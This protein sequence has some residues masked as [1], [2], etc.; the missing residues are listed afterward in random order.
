MN[1]LSKIKEF[2]SEKFSTG[3][4]FKF[5]YNT[6]ID[7]YTRQKWEEA[8]DYFKLAIE[9]DKIKPQ[10]YYNL[11][12]CYQRIKDYDKAVV[13]YQKFLEHNPT[14]Y[15]GLYNIAL[16]Y[17][18][19]GDFSKSVEFYEKCVEIKKD[20]DGVKSLALA[21][22][23]NNETQ[24]AI[25]FANNIFETQENGLILYY[26]IAQVFENKNAFGKDFTYIDT[27]IEM[28]LK[29][30]EKDSNF[31]D[32]YL[33]ISICYAKKAE[34]TKSVEFCEKA[35]KTNPNS[36]EA[37]NQMGL[38]YYCSNEI[39]EAVK[40]YE[41][42]LKLK[43]DGDYKIYSNLAYAYEKAEKYN[44][45][46]RIFTKLLQKFPDFPAKDEIKN[47]MRILKSS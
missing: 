39:N 5:F 8:I 23:S 42:A 38:V 29:I 9:Q 40:Y 43:P 6:G 12:L 35:L 20:K 18:M 15:D 3:K 1:K 41:I 24:K 37:N 45:A 36:Y 19:R 21:Y 28:Y 44:D 34:F 13:N 14:D 25:D 46:I 11:A 32:A 4:N 31:F 22:L 26:E 10:V 33:A 47:H 2:I 30:L 7:F 16:V 27:A 17:F